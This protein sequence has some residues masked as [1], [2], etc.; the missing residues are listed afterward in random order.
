MDIYV[1]PESVS[2]DQPAY[3]MHQES[4]VFKGEKQYDLK[5]WSRE[6][7]E[8]FHFSLT[9]T[10]GWWKDT[11]LA[12][13]SIVYGEQ[14]F[15]EDG[16]QPFSWEAIPFP[17]G[18]WYQIQNWPVVQQLSILTQVCFGT[19]KRKEASLDDHPYVHSK[20][21]VDQ[22][23]CAFCKS[24][25]I[26]KQKVFEGKYCQIL[27]DYRP[28]G[29]GEDKI[30]FLVV[31]K[32]HRQGYL[33]MTDEEALEMQELCQRLSAYVEKTQE[34]G[35]LYLFHKTGRR[36]GQNVPH[37]HC[38]VIATKNRHADCWS[39]L[40]MLWRI[41]GLANK[42]IGDK[43]LAEKVSFYKEEFKHLPPVAAT[44]Q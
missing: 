6:E 44:S 3:R 15:A 38:H 12:T 19:F 26:E 9:N 18:S 11:G 24:E 29:L 31:P 23:P 28:I 25:V 32:E 2:S 36:A 8:L 4:V 20:P 7:N 37:Y 14:R 33:D 27:Y 13:D 16:A 5:N 10:L 42:P 17:K 39:K 1:S 34:V 22:R 35:S 21:A 40:T 43:A 41:S 30:H